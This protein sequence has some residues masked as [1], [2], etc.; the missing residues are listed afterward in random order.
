[1]ATS[2]LDRNFPLAESNEWLRVKH[3]IALPEEFCIAG[4]IIIQEL[5]G[6]S[7][8]LQLMCMKYESSSQGKNSNLALQYINIHK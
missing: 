5:C 8:G 4:T 7:H 6:C 3:K 1:M 2:C